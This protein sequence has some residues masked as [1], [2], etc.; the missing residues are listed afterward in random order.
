MPARPPVLR[1]PS[2]R[3]PHQRGHCA[4]VR[5]THN[6]R[7]RYIPI[8]AV[9][10]PCCAGATCWALVV[11][12]TR[13]LAR[14]RCGGEPAECCGALRSRPLRCVHHEQHRAVHPAAHWPVGGL[15]GLAW[16]VHVL[17]AVVLQR[18]C[19]GRA[20]PGLGSGFPW[21]TLGRAGCG[22]SGCCCATGLLVAGGGGGA[23]AGLA[24]GRPHTSMSS[25]QGTK[26]CMHVNG[27]Q[28]HTPAALAL[29]G[30]M[31]GRRR[32]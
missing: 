3:A 25:H 4:C 10:L 5:S 17:A 16:L 31:G 1:R 12:H 7:P 21:V 23:N 20:L 19:A 9:T 28:A 11:G 29:T 18:G 8:Y 26:S 30:V 27:R 24:R 22:P 13:R 2:T 6:N 14:R 15:P 32:L